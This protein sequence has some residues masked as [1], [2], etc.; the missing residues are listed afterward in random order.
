MGH[1]AFRQ[2]DGHEVCFP[3]DAARRRQ[4][5]APRIHIAIREGPAMHMMLV[6]WMKGY[7]KVYIARRRMII[8][9]GALHWQRGRGHRRVR[10]LVCVAWISKIARHE[11]WSSPR[12]C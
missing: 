10:V 4:A 3:S 8:S 2:W 7:V 9:W 6:Q 11:F 1:M 5:M 12:P